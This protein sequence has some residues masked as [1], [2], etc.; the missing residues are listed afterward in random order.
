MGFQY[1]FTV[2]ASFLLGPI[3]LVQSFAYLR[4]GIYTK[5]FKG[6]SRKEYIR[7]DEKP[8]EY[9]FSVIFHFGISFVMIGVGFWL[10]EDIPAVEHWYGEIR[11]I[12]Y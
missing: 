10:L 5:T 1:S 4:R 2:C 9:W 3:A 7:K 6:T 12:F 8:I 11:A